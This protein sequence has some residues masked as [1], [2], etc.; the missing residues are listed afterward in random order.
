MNMYDYIVET[1]K[2]SKELMDNRILEYKEIVKLFN[3]N[4]YDEIVFV[5]SG[6]SYNAALTTKYFME[7]MLDTKVSCIY[8]YLLLNFEKKINEKALYIFISQS[9]ESKL[10]YNAIE[11]I[12]EITSSIVS[13]TSNKNSSI[14]KF[15]NISIDMNCGEEIVPYKTKGYICTLISIIAI[16]LEL[17]KGKNII[18]NLKYEE[19]V[20]NIY[21]IISNMKN[22]INKSEYWYEENINNMIDCDGVIVCGTGANYGTAHEAHL[23]IIE[24]VRCFTSFYE[25]EEY[26]HGPQNSLNNRFIV[27]GI[28]SGTIENEKINTLFNFLKSKIDNAYIVGPSGDIDINF[29]GKDELKFIEMTIFFQVFAYKYSKDKKIDLSKRTFEDFDKVVGKKV[30]N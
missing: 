9:G 4:D 28:N 19:Y 24:T 16:T 5:G 2:F 3:E 11:K 23:K 10:T 8:P 30:N 27:F 1:N 14:S 25:L 13:L 17:A 20:E 26:M 7:N 22:I 15:A 12:K 21:S 18:D 6:S 29:I